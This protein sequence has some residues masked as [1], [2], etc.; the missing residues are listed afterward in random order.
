MAFGKH[1]VELLSFSFSLNNY[2]VSQVAKRLL[3]LYLKWFWDCW[4]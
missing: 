2:I 4:I 3:I 1:F